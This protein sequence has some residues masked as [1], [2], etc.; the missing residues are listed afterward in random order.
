MNIPV[1][2]FL[3]SGG[4]CCRCG[5]SY[6]IRYPIVELLAATV[7]L[8]IWYLYGVSSQGIFLA[9]FTLALIAV[10][11]IDLDWRII[12]DSISIGGWILAIIL[13]ALHHSGFPV[14][15]MESIAGS[16]GGAAFFLITGKGFEWLTGREGLGGGDVKLMGFIGAVIG[17]HG[18]ITTVLFGSIFGIIVG[19]ILAFCRRRAIMG[20]SVP[21]GPF[22]ALGAFLHILQLD[23]WLWNYLEVVR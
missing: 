19:V 4:R 8:S 12:P 1:L 2:S 20:Y 5:L 16:I 7:L 22:L 17:I 10:S 18:M 23:Q 6:S 21:F 15:L 11:F 3:I 14:S 9:L 13:S